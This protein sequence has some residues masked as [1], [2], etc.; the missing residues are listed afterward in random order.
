MA[1]P[2]FCQINLSEGADSLANS[3]VPVEKTLSIME[4]IS[5]GGTGGIIIMLT[6]F[7]LSIIAVYIF[8][9]RYMTI[10][11]AGNEDI[12]F[13]NEIKDFIHDGKLEAARSL[14]KSN[15]TPIAK[16]IE[17]GVNRIGKPLNDIAAAIENTGKLE[18]FKLEK[19]LATLATI[20]GAAPMIGFLGTVIGMI[21]A[22]H[23]MAS[24]GGN[25]DVEMLSEGIY[26]AMVTTVAGLI[27]GIVA[28]IGYNLLVAKVEKVVFKMEART[29]EFLDI[30]NEPAK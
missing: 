23:Q 26:T 9:E 15:A 19:G 27:V 17:K 7:I 5:S 20:S 16:M 1:T 14:C 11:K 12:N 8:I 10:K 24:A 22:F 21:L 2:I 18:L 30:L 13:M 28:F 25:I 6:L 29:T 3:E 4:L